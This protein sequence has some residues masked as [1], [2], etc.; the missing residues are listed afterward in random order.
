VRSIQGTD[1]MV[2]GLDFGLTESS[3]DAESSKVSS[4]GKWV[5]DFYS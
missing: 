4:F 3:K 2:R 1:M 5:H